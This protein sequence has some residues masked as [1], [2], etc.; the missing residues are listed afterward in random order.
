MRVDRIVICFAALLLA[1]LTGC[2]RP[3]AAPSPPG[4]KPVASS[5]Q[6]EVVVNKATGEL[7]VAHKVREKTVLTWT[8]ATGVPEPFYIHFEDRD[9]CKEGG[10]LRSSHGEVTCTVRSSA[11]TLERYVISSSATRPTFSSGPVQFV[12][13]CKFC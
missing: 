6:L 7:H 13:N 9:F 1:A 8:A 5:L 2:R 3:G 10:E 12:H 11:D 4:G